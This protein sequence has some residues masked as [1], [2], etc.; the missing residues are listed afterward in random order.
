MALAVD[1][2]GRK[3]KLLPIGMFLGVYIIM[4]TLAEISGGGFNPARSIGPA[5]IVG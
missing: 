4:M 1:E 2:K 5:I 3:M